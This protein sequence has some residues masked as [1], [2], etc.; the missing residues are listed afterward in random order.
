MFNPR[1]RFQNFSEYPQHFR[2]QT[3]RA[4]Q[5]PRQNNFVTSGPPGARTKHNA[6]YNPAQ[7]FRNKRHIEC[8]A[9]GKRGHYA[10]ECRSVPPLSHQN[11]SRLIE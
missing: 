4:H 11:S 3:F 2:N 1:R 5:V 7:R 10:R 9:C 6:W 8:Y